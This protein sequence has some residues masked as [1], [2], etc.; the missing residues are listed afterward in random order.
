M[1]FHQDF[2]DSRDA[3][4][5][6][7]Y[8]SAA[9]RQASEAGRP[10][11]LKTTNWKDL[12]SSHSAVSVARKIEK[13]LRYVAV[14]CVHPGTV[15]SLDPDW[16]YPIAD[17][18]GSAEFGEYVDHLI[19][20]KLIRAFWETDRQGEQGVSGYS[21]TIEGWQA[22]EPSVPPG[23]IA[24]TCFVAMWFSSAMNEAYELGI[25][26]A[27]E[28]D[29][30]LKA[31]R[32]DR[33]AHN[34]QITDEIMAGIRRAEFM[35]ADFTGQRAGVYYESGFAKG[36]GREVI[37]TCRKGSFKRRHFDTSVMNHLV[38]TDSGELRKKLADHIAATILRKA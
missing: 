24:G 22:V 34:R 14:K 18:N 4:E 21:P 8:L 10:L 37:Y 3:D 23:G 27:I 2:P 29:N 25:R 28:D 30:G 17:C 15:S 35:V 19:E 32:I 11:T 5:L 36:L 1:E 31:I 33:V 13:V 6:R 12:A 26:P 20:K 38:W 7:P 9:T 16:D